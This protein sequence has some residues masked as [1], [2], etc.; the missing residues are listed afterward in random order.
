V[1]R[2]NGLVMDGAQVP[3]AKALLDRDADLV[4]HVCASFSDASPALELYR[5]LGRPARRI[6]Y[7]SGASRHPQQRRPKIRNA[8]RLLAMSVESYFD[9]SNIDGYQ[10]RVRRHAVLFSVVS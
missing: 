1:L 5:E 9:L 8:P 4:V 6:R 10:P 3:A 2:P 7:T